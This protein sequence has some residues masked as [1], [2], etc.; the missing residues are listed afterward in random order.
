[1]SQPRL[2]LRR[3]VCLRVHV[4]RVGTVL[5]ERWSGGGGGGVVVV[6][7][8]LYLLLL[9]LLLLGRWRRQ[10]RRLE[11]GVQTVGWWG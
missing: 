5:V 1:M 8:A 7:I 9:L 11:G 3:P 4:S 2:R 6:G 10:P